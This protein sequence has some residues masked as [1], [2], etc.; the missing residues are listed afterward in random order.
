MVDAAEGTLIP[1]EARDQAGAVRDLVA[2]FKRSPTSATRTADLVPRAW[3]P[4]LVAALLLLAL[5]HRPSGAG[6]GRAWRACCCSPRPA[7][8]QRP[9]RG[10][11]R[12]RGR[13]SRPVPPPSF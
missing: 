3:I 10:R 11:A 13:R 7:A 2:A 9:D 1:S 5:H 4:G 6:A 8:A 12:A